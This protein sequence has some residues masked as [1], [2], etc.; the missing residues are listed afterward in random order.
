MK[1]AIFFLL[2]FVG[3]LSAAY[4]EN[5]PQFFYP[6]YQ[7]PG[8]GWILALGEHELRAK[9]SD[10]IIELE[11][12]TQFK[13]IP[14]HHSILQSWDFYDKITMCP[15]SSLYPFRD[16]QFYIINES[17]HEYCKANIWASAVYENPQALHLI[18]IDYKH[19]EILLGLQDGTQ[20]RWAIHPQ[21]IDFLRHW[22]EGDLIVTGKNSSWFWNYFSG[23]EYILINYAAA[24]KAVYVRVAPR[25]L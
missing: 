20:T 3:S 16:S 2:A 4:Q 19:Q 24:K 21:D 10:G 5:K 17:K 11:D 12:E 14:G 8:V 18:K 1:K 7:P 13:T 25:P 15:N 22:R 6:E 23:Y 9:S